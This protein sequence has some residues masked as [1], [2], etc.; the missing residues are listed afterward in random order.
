[1]K[2]ADFTRCLFSS[3][4]RNRFSSP[5]V[6]NNC[7]SGARLLFHASGSLSTSES[8]FLEY[9]VKSHYFVDFLHANKRSW[10]ICVIEW[11]ISSCDLLLE[12]LYVARCVPSLV[13]LAKTGNA[14]WF[15]INLGCVLLIY[16][17]YF[18]NESQCHL[19]VFASFTHF[20]RMFRRESKTC[21][22]RWSQWRPTM[23]SLCHF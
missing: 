10:V 9:S 6:W 5:P 18:V 17:F 16:G 13:A 3:L 2:L 20:V 15:S 21:D 4:Q 22:V 8:V 1:M 11:P 23:S 7:K 14:Q 12:G 19:L